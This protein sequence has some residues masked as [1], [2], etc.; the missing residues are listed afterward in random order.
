MRVARRSLIFAVFFVTLLI[1][2]AS[3][4]YAIEFDYSH[5]GDVGI[6]VVEV[7]TGTPVIKMNETTRYQPASVTK[8]LSIL[9][10]MDTMSLTDQITFDAGM[11][12]IV[13]K[14][15][16]LAGLV[17]GETMSFERL[18]YAMLLPSGNDAA[19]ALGVACARIVE[20]NPKMPA[21]EAM[22]K[23]A[24]LM[25][26]KAKQIG[27]VDSNF[28][29]PDGYPKPE[30]YSTAVDISKLGIAALKNEQIMKVARTTDI[31]VKTNKKSHRWVNTNRL[32]HE[33][34]EVYGSKGSNPSFDDRVTGLKTGSAGSAGRSL[35]FSA[36]DD[37]LEIIGVLMHVTS[38]SKETIFSAAQKSN[39]H[40]FGNYQIVNLAEAAQKR[41][42][43]KVTNPTF[44]SLGGINLQASTDPLVCLPKE[45]SG[46]LTLKINTNNRLVSLN[47]K[48]SLS[49][50]ENIRKGDEIIYYDYEYN[51]VRLFRLTYTAN[52]S[53]EKAT[54]RDAVY[55]AM[56][57]MVLFIGCNISGYVFKQNR[58]VIS[59]A[60]RYS[61]RR[62]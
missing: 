46:K 48:G 43:Y 6:Y 44:L 14:G 51:G 32:L 62:L 50:K 37:D 55:Y 45:V 16:S 9:T 38:A 34:Y 33:T 23:F 49:L 57:F 28:T 24:D 61:R 12:G 53:Y 31:T 42:N 15:S 26:A 54:F 5:F 21:K 3:A 29:N 10:A 13:E 7:S 59:R 22:A 39:K 60:K 41:T 25:N 20:K 52:T 17:V 4:A 47:T 19:R 27:M 30:I 8:V 56:L 2:T 58:L 18:M 36:K 40:V 11:N 35:L 1:T